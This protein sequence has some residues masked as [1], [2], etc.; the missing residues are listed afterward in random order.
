MPNDAGYKTL[1]SRTS[2]ASLHSTK[3]DVSKVGPDGVEN[4]IHDE[5]DRDGESHFLDALPSAM[6]PTVKRGETK[7]PDVNITANATPDNFNSGTLRSI[8]M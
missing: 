3:D 5:N 1:T 2:P 8:V 7:M 6:V 4:H